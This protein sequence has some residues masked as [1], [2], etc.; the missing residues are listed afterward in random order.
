[1]KKNFLT[2]SL[3]LVFALTGCSQKNDLDVNQG[4]NNDAGSVGEQSYG[5]G[6]PQEVTDAMKSLFESQGSNK[7]ICKMTVDGRYLTIPESGSDIQ[8]CLDKIEGVYKNIKEDFD[9]RGGNPE[10]IEITSQRDT[11]KY[12]MFDDYEKKHSDRF[13]LIRFK[14]GEDLDVFMK[15]F[16][17]RGRW[18]VGEEGNR[19]LGE[20]ITA[21]PEVL[22]NLYE[23][24]M[25]SDGERAT[26]CNYLADPQTQKIIDDPRR[27][28]ECDKSIKNSS[29]NRDS[30]PSMTIHD[31]F[32]KTEG[33]SSEEKI[34][35]V[36]EIN[37]ELF[38][39]ESDLLN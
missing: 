5:G 20:P 18:Y 17:V 19:V 32:A 12:S 33:V 7:S 38:L 1:M 25:E 31:G 4:E 29:V 9:Y 34:I 23:D 27:I 14:G 8:D 11:D 30:S 39:S 37:N 22:E 28:S 15:V 35:Q 21:T 24:D 2:M 16:Q 26:I 13:S 3:I 6:S 10:K 36:I